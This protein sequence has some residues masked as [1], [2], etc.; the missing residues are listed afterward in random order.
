MSASRRFDGAVVAVTGSARGI[1][2]TIARAF[3]AEGAVVCVCDVDEDAGAAAAE[4]LSAEGVSSEFVAVQ[5]AAPGAPR[6]MVEEVCGRRGR[7]DVLINNAAFRQRRD[8][9]EETEESW[10]EAMAVNLR[11]A[12]FASQAAVRAMSRTGGGAIVNIASVTGQL[13]AAHESATYHIAKAGLLQMARYLAVV[14]GPFGVRVNAIAPGFIVQE[15]HRARYHSAGNRHYRE[16][17]EFAHPLGRVG[18]SN[19]VARAA[20]Y[21]ASDEAKFVNGQCLVVDGGLT[22]QEPSSLLLRFSAERS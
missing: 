2:K 20:V 7:L 4:E 17:A 15:A 19:D 22:L 10:D 21:L 3:G 5:L 6:A 8:F 11:A 14:A 1:G 16:Q 9:L 18:C 13:V 12:F